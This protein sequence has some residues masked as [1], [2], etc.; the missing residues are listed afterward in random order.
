MVSGPLTTVSVS[1]RVIAAL[2][3]KMKEVD[4]KM[5]EIDLKMREI[6]LKMQKFRSENTKV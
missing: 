4:L 6:D 1:G 5:R 2:D 3:L